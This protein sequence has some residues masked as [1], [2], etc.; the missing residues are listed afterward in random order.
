MK[1]VS[2]INEASGAK[3]EELNVELMQEFAYGAQGDICPVQAFIG[4]ITAQEI[5][6]VISV[7]L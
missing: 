6:K 4:G 7:N 5:M 1:L 2:E 3:V